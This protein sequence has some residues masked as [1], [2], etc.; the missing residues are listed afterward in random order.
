MVELWLL[1]FACYLAV[2]D[3]DIPQK[4]MFLVYNHMDQSLTQPHHKGTVNFI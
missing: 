1:H 4:M 3:S 2:M